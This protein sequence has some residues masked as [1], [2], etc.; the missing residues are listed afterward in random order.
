M[1]ISF[2][3]AEYVVV[4]YGT[5]DILEPEVDSYVELFEGVGVGQ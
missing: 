5:G 3:D 4:V 1:W 2:L